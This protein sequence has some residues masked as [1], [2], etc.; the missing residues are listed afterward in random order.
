MS[1]L[2]SFASSAKP[3]MLPYFEA[4]P[5]PAAQYVGSQT[6]K[7]PVFNLLKLILSPLSVPCVHVAHQSKTKLDAMRTAPVSL[8]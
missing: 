6:P 8:A 3:F 4:S 1:S 7:L 5:S 2:R